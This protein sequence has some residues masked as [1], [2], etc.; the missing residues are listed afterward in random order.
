MG[1][2]LLIYSDCYVYG[3]SERLINVILNSEVINK[4]YQL[5]FAYSNHK[6]YREGLQK[7]YQNE[8]SDFIALPIFPPATLR[9]VLGELK[10]NIALKWTFEKCLR[11]LEVTG[12]VFIYNLIVQLFVLSRVKPD[13]VHINN[14]GF[15]GAESCSTMVFACVLS[16]IKKNVYHVN[17]FALETKSPFRKIFDRKLNLFVN[18]FITASK[19][20][21]AALSSVRGFPLEK[22]KQL[23]NAIKEETVTITKEQLLSSYSLK[24]TSFV[25]CQVAFLSE[26]KGQIN[27]LKALLTIKTLHRTMYENSV[28]FLVGNGEDEKLLRSFANENGLLD[29]VVFTGF[30]PDS[31]NFINAA[32]VFVLPSV[33]NE[34]MPLVILT[35]MSLGKEIVATRLAGIK[36]QIEDGVSGILLDPDSTTLPSALTDALVN[37]YENRNNRSLGSTAKLHFKEKFTVQ[38]YGEKLLGI[39]DNLT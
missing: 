31:I 15:P 24:I 13:I 8:I 38:K 30:R 29:K 39:Y 35:A 16:G 26:R 12:L 9:R 28:L 18:V 17:N 10:I 2:K 25:L 11:I 7:E 19:D 3:G 37:V 4:K 14:G 6:V 1:N 33:A 36:E 21:R 20:T 32:D 23:P 27:L 34:D 5:Y 22:I